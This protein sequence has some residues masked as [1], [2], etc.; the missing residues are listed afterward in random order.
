MNTP[1]GFPEGVGVFIFVS[2]A[3]NVGPNPIFQ[4]T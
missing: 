2:A 1:V 3:W 4:A